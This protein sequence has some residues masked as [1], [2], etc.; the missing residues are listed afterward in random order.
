MSQPTHIKNYSAGA[1]I[2]G[3]RIVKYDTSDGQAVQA[4]SATDALMGIAD[5]L[6]ADAADDRVDVIKAGIAEVELGGTV[7]RGDPLTADADGKAVA[8]APVA[9]ANDRIIGFA[10]VSGVAGDIID[11]F[12]A[13]GQIQG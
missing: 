11:C 3:Y 1:A 13:P 4:T 10:E 5:R 12:I 2:S 9:G 8:A 7:T 6:G